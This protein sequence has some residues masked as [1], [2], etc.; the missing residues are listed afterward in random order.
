[1]ET[2]QP[3]E[4]TALIQSAESYKRF[5]LCLELKNAGFPQRRKYGSM[6]YVR[7][8]M[9]INISDLSVL[10]SDGDTDFEN[11]FTTLVFKPTL[12][13][14]ERESREFFDQIRWTV[15]SGVFAYSKFRKSDAEDDNPDP[16]IRAGAGDEWTARA[17]LWLEQKKSIP[18]DISSNID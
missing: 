4:G 7:Q 14:L 6:Y 17:M 18:K 3:I 11:V 10:K 15:N 5:L 9:L 12:D 2:G 16:Y 13:D 1:M 8:D